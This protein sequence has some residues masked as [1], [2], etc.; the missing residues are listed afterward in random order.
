MGVR[1][2]QNPRG[3]PGAAGCAAARV[4]LKQRGG[5]LIV[6]EARVVLV[7]GVGLGVIVALVR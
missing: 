1:V 3:D 4:G 5:I 2:V 7:W 6:W